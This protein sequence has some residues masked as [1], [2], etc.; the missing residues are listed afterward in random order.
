MSQEPLLF[1]YSIWD[2]ILYSKP[3]ANDDEITQATDIANA[4]DFIKK[5]EVSDAE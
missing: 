5:L 1:N 3:T 2:N 4:T